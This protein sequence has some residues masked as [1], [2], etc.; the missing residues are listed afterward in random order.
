MQDDFEL[1]DEFVFGD[2][3]PGIFTYYHQEDAEELDRLLDNSP[4]E[5]TFQNEG[6]DRHN[7]VISL[8]ADRSL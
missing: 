4:I 8:E 6:A 2:P 3:F 1:I 7:L 5:V